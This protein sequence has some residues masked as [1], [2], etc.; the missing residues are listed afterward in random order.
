MM[1][2]VQKDLVKTKNAKAQKDCKESEKVKRKNNEKKEIKRKV[3]S[4]AKNYKTT[5]KTSD[6]KYKLKKGNFKFEINIQFVF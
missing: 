4:K 6:Q 3:N 2:K 5:K 1:D